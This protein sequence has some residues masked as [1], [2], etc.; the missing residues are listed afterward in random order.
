[1][2]DYIPK[3]IEQLLAIEQ[4]DGIR[5]SVTGKPTQLEGHQSN[6]TYPHYM[7][8][9]VL[10]SEKGSRMPFIAEK[11]SRENQPYYADLLGAAEKHGEQVTAN[12]LYL[13]VEGKK[14]FF[15][16]GLE[17]RAELVDSEQSI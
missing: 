15:V 17:A 13:I 6:G 8:R 14:F 5:V 7:M 3:T 12:G 4:T 16:H 11:L 1:M 2:A 10:E 9:G